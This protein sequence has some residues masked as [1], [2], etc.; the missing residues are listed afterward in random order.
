MKTT[1]ENFIETHSGSFCNALVYAVHSTNFTIQSY[2]AGK[3]NVGRNCR[4]IIATEQ[5]YYHR[6]MRNIYAPKEAFETVFYGNA[7]FEGDTANFSASV[8]VDVFASCSRGYLWDFE[9]TAPLLNTDRP[10]VQY[11]FAQSG[12]YPM[13]LYVRD[14]NECWDTVR[15]TVRVYGIDAAFTVSDTIGCLPLAVSFTDNTVADTTV[16][17]W[18]WWFGDLSISTAQNP[19]HTYTAVGSYTATVTATNSVN[20][21]VATTQVNVID[22]SITGLTATNNG[23]TRLGSPTAFTAAILD[24]SNVSIT[25]LRGLGYLLEQRDAP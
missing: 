17:S 8:P 11:A 13:A 2:L 14:E 7:R 4:V 3:A 6:Q 9:P 16:S 5:G 15:T 12:V 20:Q 23:P 24:G 25:T 21:V 19:S 18:F 22:R 10:S 1:D